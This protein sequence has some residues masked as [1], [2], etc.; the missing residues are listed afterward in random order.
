MVLFFKKKY[1]P[2]EKSTV[3]RVQCIFLHSPFLP[4]GL[5]ARRR[6]KSDR[7]HPLPPLPNGASRSESPLGGGTLET[8][9]KVF[10]PFLSIPEPRRSEKNPPFPGIARETLKIFFVRH[11]VSIIF[12]LLCIRERTL[13]RRQELF[14]Y[15]EHCEGS[16]PL[17]NLGPVK[18]LSPPTTRTV[19]QMIGIFFSHFLYTCPR[20]RHSW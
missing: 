4:S 13:T 3:C 2:L 11:N 16:P 12:Y 20:P 18:L 1:I 5:Y 17:S 9:K 15:R 10:L 19:Y 8:G 14:W 7:N 6:R